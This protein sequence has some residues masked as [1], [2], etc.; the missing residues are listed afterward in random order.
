MRNLFDKIG[1][2]SG[3]VYDMWL[4]YEIVLYKFA[5]EFKDINYYDRR[6]RKED[7]KYI[8][9]ILYNYKTYRD[10]FKTLLNYI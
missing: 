8:C 6:Y 9:C 5:Q 10:Y 7:Y 3:D 1:Y 2:R 4:R